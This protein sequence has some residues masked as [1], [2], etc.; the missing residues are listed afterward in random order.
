MPESNFDIHE[1]F[2]KLSAT[3]TTN[4]LF[5]ASFRYRGID[6]DNTYDRRR[7]DALDRRNTKE[8]NRVGRLLRA[9][10]RRR[11]IQPRVQVQLNDNPSGSIPVI[12]LGY[13]GVFNA[14]DPSQSGYY[15]NG[16]TCTGA[17]NVA[18]TPTTSRGSSTT[19][20]AST[21]T[22]SS[23]ASHLIKA[24]GYFSNNRGKQ[25]TL[26]N[27]WG[28]IDATTAAT[29]GNEKGA[30]G[31]GTRRSRT[32]Q[33]SRGQHDRPLPAG[34]GTWDRLTVNIGVLV[35]QDSSS[36]TTTGI[37]YR[38]GRLHRSQHDLLPCTDPHRDRAR[39]RTAPYTFPFSSQL[40]PRVGV[41]YELTPSVHDKLYANFARYDNMDNQSFARRPRAPAALPHGRVLQLDDGRLHPEIGAV[42]QHRQDRHARHQPDVH[43]RV[44][45]GYARPLG[46]GW[47]AEVYGLYP[48]H[49]GHHRGF[50]R[51]PASSTTRTT[52][53]TATSRPIASTRAGRSRSARPAATT[54]RSTRRTR[55]RS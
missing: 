48:Q 30:T 44:S 40:Q 33:I 28:A 9:T 14:A 54:G 18:T 43:R 32:R 15:C 17:S 3:P 21:S 49:E 46:G 35:N 41:S 50:P 39:A 1:Y 8:I 10:G 4:L 16:V 55:S 37:T 22:T 12:P 6:Q 52:S 42:E 27:G 53:A 13:Q 36:R 5:D 23:A 45:F 24:G 38:P 31:R 2:V 51:R 34:P 25:S 19:S 47:V 29:A 11:R 26:A 7:L 20:R